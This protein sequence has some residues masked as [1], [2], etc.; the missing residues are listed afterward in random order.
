MHRMRLWWYL[1]FGGRDGYGLDLK[2][3]LL[4]LYAVDARFSPG[5]GFYQG[6]GN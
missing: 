3:L 6:K 1:G 5:L 4:R 2:L